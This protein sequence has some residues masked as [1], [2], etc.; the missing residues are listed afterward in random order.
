MEQ[1]LL[2]EKH[3]QFMHSYPN[4][5]PVSN[6]NFNN[7]FFPNG[8]QGYIN[9]QHMLNVASQPSVI[10][11]PSQQPMAY[12][13]AVPYPSISSVSL[14]QTIPP[15]PPPPPLATVNSP[16]LNHHHHHQDH[17]PSESMTSTKDLR[18]QHQFHQQW[19]AHQDQ[20]FNNYSNKQQHDQSYN[21]WPHVQQYTTATTSINNTPMEVCD[22]KEQ[23]KLSVTDDGFPLTSVGQKDSMVAS[24]PVPQQQKRARFDSEN[25]ICTSPTPDMYYQFLPMKMDQKEQLPRLSPNELQ[26][27]LTRGGENTVPVLSPVHDNRAQFSEPPFLLNELQQN[28]QESELEENPIAEHDEDDGGERSLCY[29]AHPE[30]HPPQPTTEEELT[31][32]KMSEM[33]KEQEEWSKIDFVKQQQLQ[34]QGYDMETETADETGSENNMFDKSSMDHQQQHQ[35]EPDS[36]YFVKNDISGTHHGGD[37]DEMVLDET[38][39]AENH[40]ASTSMTSLE[41]NFLA[42]LQSRQR[43]HQVMD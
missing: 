17:V 19:N 18:Q 25:N 43:D 31:V 24:Y 22:V 42:I 35:R 36:C 23:H 8:L 12:P 28:S 15:P 41:R 26:S 39:S 34:Q 16:S 21:Q 20:F 5:K 1:Q 7:I 37:D 10:M 13:P 6:L 4:T 38:T 32:D 40:Q 27:I 33:M 29:L 9:L 2:R 14:P 3:E 30:P 11:P